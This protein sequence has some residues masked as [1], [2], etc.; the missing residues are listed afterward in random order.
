[1]FFEKP[2]ATSPDAAKSIEEAKAVGEILKK[3]RGHVS[4][5]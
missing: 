3:H 2:V 4:I 1:L 5:G